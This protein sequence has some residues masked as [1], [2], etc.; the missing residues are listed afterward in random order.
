MRSFLSVAVF[1]VL[2]AGVAAQT[3]AVRITEGSVKTSDGV[4]I[5]VVEAGRGSSILFVP[6]F[7]GAAEFWEAQIQFFAK[8]H[9][10]VAMDP[11]S[12]GDSEKTAEGNFTER[13][14]KDIGDVITMLKL[15]PVVVVA[16]SRAVSE[17]LNYVDEFGSAAIR[18]LVLVDGAVTR[19]PGP[20]TLA[21]LL[22]EAKAMQQDRFAYAN[23]S[24][25][26][27]FRRPHSEEFYSRIVNATLKTPTAVAVALQADALQFDYRAGLRNIN[28]PLMFVS[29]GDMPSVQAK[30]V[31]GEVPAAR[32]ETMPGSGHAV[33]LDDP[34]GFNKLLEEFLIAIRRN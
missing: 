23:R 27:M 1:A 24:A 9:R 34:E 31:L 13:R 22:A 4:R 17:I 2:A 28:R 3:T 10:A 14:A 8:S 16:W 33:F 18:G 12:Q 21:N 7:T 15:T 25:R 5:H 30:L 6:G 19:T 32:L 11:R 20:Q 26:G 29:Q